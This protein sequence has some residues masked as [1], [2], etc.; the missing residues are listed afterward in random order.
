MCYSWINT[1]MGRQRLSHYNTKNCIVNGTKRDISKCFAFSLKDRQVPWNCRNLPHGLQNHS[2]RRLQCH[3]W[4]LGLNQINKKTSLFSFGHK[5]KLWW[6]WPP[7]PTTQWG[8]CSAMGRTAPSCCC[9]GTR[10]CLSN[11]SVQQNSKPQDCLL[12]QL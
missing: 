4:A 3:D 6:S 12:W 2:I 8:Y 11:Q 7:C 1:S 10:G 5:P 9:W